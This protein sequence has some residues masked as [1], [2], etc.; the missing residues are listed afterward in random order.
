[1][2]AFLPITTQNTTH[3]KTKD[4]YIVTIKQKSN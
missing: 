4:L 2:K 1:M 3:N